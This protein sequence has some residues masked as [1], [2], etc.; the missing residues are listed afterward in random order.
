MSNYTR[1][2]SGEV[3]VTIPIRLKYD[4]RKTVIHLPEE[5][6][7]PLTA[8]TMNPMQKALIQ[9]FQ[10]RD[11]LESGS[12]ATLSALARTEKQDRIFMYHS[13]ELVNFAP[14]IIT[15]ILDGTVPDTFTLARLR[16]GIPVDWEQQRKEFGFP[17]KN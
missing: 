11:R 10:Y 16:K 4:G 17:T 5:T 1:L 9:G 3:E 2:P 7:G 6:P 13:L 14:D 15:A 12:A 8:E